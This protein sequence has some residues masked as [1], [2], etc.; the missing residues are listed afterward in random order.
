MKLLTTPGDWQG[1]D[2]LIYVICIVLML[3][4]LID[5][6]FKYIYPAILSILSEPEDQ[7]ED[8][9]FSPSQHFVE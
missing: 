4:L 8:V 1:Q 2:Y 9:E 6:L 5:M 7:N 3:Y